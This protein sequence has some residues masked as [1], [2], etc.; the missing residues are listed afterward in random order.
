M[1]WKSRAWTVIGSLAA[2]EDLKDTKICRLSSVMKT[3]NSQHVESMPTQVERPS[4][5]SASTMEARSSSSSGSDNQSE[6][7]LRTVMYLSCWGPN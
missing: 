6:E 2:V 1:S 4:S 3:F 7:A 5:S